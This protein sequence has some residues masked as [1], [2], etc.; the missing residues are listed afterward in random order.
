MNEE[1]NSREISSKKIYVLWNVT[2]FDVVDADQNIW[3][4]ALSVFGVGV[5]MSKPA[6]DMQEEQSD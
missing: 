6:E 1:K 4:L 3:R 2:P 5:K